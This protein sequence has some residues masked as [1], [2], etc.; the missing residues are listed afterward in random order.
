MA[1]WTYERAGVSLERAEAFVEYIKEKVR[2]LRKQVILFGG[3]ASGVEL[4]GYKNPVLMLATDGVGTKL[5]VAQKVGVHHTVGIDLVAMNVNDLLTSGAEPVAFLDYIA[6]GRI[7][8]QVL[9]SVM[10]GIVE[11]C[12]IADIPLVGGE[13]AEM[14]DF[15]PEGVYDLAGF[16]VG[17]CEREELISGKDIKPGHVIV[18]LPSSGF[19][20]N[21]YSLV[22][23][24]L[25]EKGI[26]YDD[27]VEGLGK[28]V[29]ELLLEPTRIYAQEV[30]RLKS[31]GLKIRG[32]AHITGG[33]IPGN[34]VRILPEG[35]RAVVDTSCIPK[36]P[37]FEWIGEL[38]RV[39]VEE[40]YR[41]FNM[42]VGFLFV[43]EKEEG[44]GVLSI[45]EEAFVCGRVEEGNRD[46]VIL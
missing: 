16:C 35:C 30:K 43:L 34:L 27:P 32:M 45:L 36:N 33:G 1:E 29:W 25:E 18:G 37:L 41:T 15:Y 14:P 12:R 22:R 38:G 42:G 7:D 6:T 4:K 13:T 31:S 9:C 17:V 46:V 19:H 39:R 26:S 24:I 3:F 11:G 20:S 2:L 8:L 44:E 23:K 5:K 10:D 40:M 21:G 28:R